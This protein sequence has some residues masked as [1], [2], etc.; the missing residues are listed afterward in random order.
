MT[1]ATGQNITDGFIQYNNKTRMI[2]VITASP[3][4]VGRYIY[5]I[6]GYFII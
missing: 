1:N 3:L 2:T 4:V 5:N 6:T